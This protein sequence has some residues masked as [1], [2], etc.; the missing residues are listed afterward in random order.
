M[1][2]LKK[3]KDKVVAHAKLPKPIK[4]V[5]DIERIEIKNSQKLLI[6]VKDNSQIRLRE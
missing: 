1:D 4:I 6:L 2:V 5:L 3:L